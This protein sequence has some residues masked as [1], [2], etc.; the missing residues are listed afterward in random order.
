MIYPYMIYLWTLSELGLSVLS[1]D[2]A[3]AETVQSDHTDSTQ[4]LIGEGERGGAD[5]TVSVHLLL[6][7][8]NV[9]NITICLN[10]WTSLLVL[11]VSFIYRLNLYKL[12]LSTTAHC[13]HAVV[14][15]KCTL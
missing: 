14:K 6:L 3:R 13:E 5:E 12:H 2:Q 7:Q 15:M 9:Y 8:M 10:R 11:N 4:P 1:A